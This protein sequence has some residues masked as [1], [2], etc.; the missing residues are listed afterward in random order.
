MLLHSTNPPDTSFSMMAT[1]VAG[2]PSP[3]R[4]VPFRMSSLPAFSMTNRR[5]GS[6][7]GLGDEVKC[8]VTEVVTSSKKNT[9]QSRQRTCQLSRHP[10][11]HLP[12]SITFPLS[13]RAYSL[14]NLPKRYPIIHSAFTYVLC[15]YILYFL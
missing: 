2:A 13:F 3:R 5:G 15:F 6:V 11:S 14:S 4:S 12:R 7:W 10:A 8:S 9:Y 1:L